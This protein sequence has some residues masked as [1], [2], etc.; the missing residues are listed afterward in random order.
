VPTERAQRR[1]LPHPARFYRRFNRRLDQLSVPAAVNESLIAGLREQLDAGGDP[2]SGVYWLLTAR[3]AEMALLCAGHYADCGETGAAGD[4][5][6]N[7]R[8]VLV[9]LRGAPGPLLKERHR[10]LSDQ[11][12]PGGLSL[13]DFAAWFRD[14]A[15]THIAEPALLKAFRSRLEGCGRMA[16]YLEG[17]KARL[18]RVADVMRFGFAARSPQTGRPHPLT[19]GF[20]TVE[21][22]RLGR[23]VIR[24]CNTPAFHSPYLATPVVRQDIPHAV[25]GLSRRDVFRAAT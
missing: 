25:A 20:D 22:R 6:L 13:P 8:R 24:I 17:F 4:L 21:Y 19:C 2:R 11:F 1:S 14:N 15:M 23:H 7:P 9:Y 16:A 12:N 18:S 5:L 3:L 10:P